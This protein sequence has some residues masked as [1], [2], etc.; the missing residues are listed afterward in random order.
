M[1]RDDLIIRCDGV[2]YKGDIEK[3]YGDPKKIKKIGF[4][5]RYNLEQGLKKTLL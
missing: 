3:W 5:Q 2:T 1:E 4:N